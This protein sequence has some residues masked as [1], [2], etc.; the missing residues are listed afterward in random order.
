M[1]FDLILRGLNRLI[2]VE[3]SLEREQDI[4]IFGFKFNRFRFIPIGLISVFSFNGL[5]RR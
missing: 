1:N 3:I 4:D 5:K 2:F